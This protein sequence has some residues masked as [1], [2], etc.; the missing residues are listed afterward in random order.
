MTDAEKLEKLE[1]NIMILETMVFG[2][3]FSRTENEALE[4]SIKYLK[5]LKSIYIWIVKGELND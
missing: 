1:N 3:G 2:K 4:N 5:E